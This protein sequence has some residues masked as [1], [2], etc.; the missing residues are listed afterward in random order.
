MCQPLHSFKDHLAKIT[1][2]E[3]HPKELLLATSSVDR[4]VRLW[5]LEQFDTV[6]NVGPEM[7]G[8]RAIMFSTDGEALLM[9]LPSGLQVLGWEPSC[10]HDVVEVP[11]MH[12]ME[13][14]ICPAQ[15]RVIGCAFKQSM[16]GLWTVGLNYVQPFSGSKSRS[17]RFEMESLVSRQKQ[18]P[19][20]DRPDLR[21]FMGQQQLL[22][23]MPVLGDDARCPPSPD[24]GSWEVDGSCATAGCPPVR[25]QQ[26]PAMHSPLPG[27]HSES[28][29]QHL[30]SSEL[31]SSGAEE[32]EISGENTRTT[33]RGS[34]V[35]PVNPPAP[36]L[37][38]CEEMKPG[39]MDSMGT[40]DTNGAHGPQVGDEG[41]LAA[42]QDPVDVSAGY[43]S[44]SGVRYSRPALTGRCM[45]P[46]DG[47][48][49][50]GH[51]QQRLP[52]RRAAS[53]SEM[54][55]CGMIPRRCGSAEPQRP[56]LRS[57]RRRVAA[58][59]L[60]ND[61]ICES[62]EDGMDASVVASAESLM[63]RPNSQEESGREPGGLDL[64]E[65][66]PRKVGK[67]GVPALIPLQS[68]IEVV[69]EILGKRDT[70]R[71][72]LAARHSNLQLLRS[73]WNRGDV[74]GALR[75]AQ[76]QENATHL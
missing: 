42:C 13:L 46:P 72:I 17:A 36:T 14:G 29:A 24:L 54:S 25:G 64:Q 51:V 20:C 44:D 5:D 18:R 48:M 58:P 68:D 38:E 31:E 39:I 21:Q 26:Q 53:Q 11:W 59:N 22:Q 62:L 71:Q 73:F 56:R 55:K 8:V 33:T 41:W 34:S 4:T 28:I 47:R 70:M 12:I 75:A 27:Y 76:R 49:Q 60:C 16:V 23:L 74:R 15:N 65:F 67:T 50:Q 69:T 3:F 37:P 52:T 6:D 35:S 32:A 57:L 45:N 2:I 30:G 9:A 43:E 7:S 61:V 66:L 10:M 63:G 1:G 40:F 19:Q